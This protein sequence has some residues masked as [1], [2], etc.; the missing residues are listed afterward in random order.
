MGIKM[1]YIDE[2][3]FMILYGSIILYVDNPI[4]SATCC[5]LASLYGYRGRS[6]FF[7]RGVPVLHYTFSPAVR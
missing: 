2:M 3:T 5:R 1:N 7:K 6:R 4:G